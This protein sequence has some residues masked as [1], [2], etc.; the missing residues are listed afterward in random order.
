M[1]HGSTSSQQ[2]QKLIGRTKPF[3]TQREGREW[4]GV[5][6]EEGLLGLCATRVG[7]ELQQAIAGA[8]AAGGAEAAGAPTSSGD[9]VAWN[10]Q[11]NQIAGHHAGDA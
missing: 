11:R 6:L 5:D 4:D 3:C 2:A 7:F 1:D 8:G 9:A 10:D